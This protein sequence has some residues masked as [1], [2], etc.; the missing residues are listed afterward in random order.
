MLPLNQCQYFHP[1][2]IENKAKPEDPAKVFFSESC[3]RLTGR[4]SQAIRNVFNIS[5]FQACPS[6]S[7]EVRS[8]PSSPTHRGCS[9][10]AR[11]ILLS[12]NHP[13]RSAW[14]IAAQGS[15]IGTSRASAGP[16]GR[17]TNRT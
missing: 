2:H 17:N 3:V 13:A 5:P 8:N 10:C 1:Q 12:T 9:P 4:Y 7:S 15:T 11:K 6:I 16:L 14:E